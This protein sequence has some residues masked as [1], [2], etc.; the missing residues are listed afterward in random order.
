MKLTD[1]GLL[2]LAELEGKVI[3]NKLHVIYSDKT[4]KPTNEFNQYSTIGYGHLLTN[5]EEFDFFSKGITEKEALN[6]LMLDVQQFE[7]IVKNRIKSRNINCEPH[8]LD[9]LI[10]HCFNT[11]KGNLNLLNFMQTTK[12][13]DLIKKCWLDNYSTQNGDFVEGLQNRRLN[14]IH[15]YFTGEYKKIC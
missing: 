7:R 9:A 12:D 8:Q 14:E 11:P 3:D 15:L 2:F 1:K 4:G 10:I 5:R 6:L 13:E